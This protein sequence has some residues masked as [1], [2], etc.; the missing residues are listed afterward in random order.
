MSQ[1]CQGRKS[2][3]DL[4]SRRQTRRPPP[5]ERCLST[6]YERMKAQPQPLFCFK[7]PCNI[8]LWIK[9]QKQQTQTASSWQLFPCSDKKRKDERMWCNVIGRFSSPAGCGWCA[10]HPS[11]RCTACPGGT[12]RWPWPPPGWRGLRPSAPGG[13]RC[14][15]PGSGWAGQPLCALAG[16][17]TPDWT[18]EWV[19][20]T[21]FMYKGCGWTVQPPGS[22]LLEKSSGPKFKVL[23]ERPASDI[24]RFI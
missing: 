2:R 5:H 16:S 24:K 8:Q 22:Q 7:V 3:A 10:S 18:V 12:G 13:G 17:P 6:C 23:L 4:T 19:W 9:L 21:E 1:F 11:R 15:A 20:V 14:R